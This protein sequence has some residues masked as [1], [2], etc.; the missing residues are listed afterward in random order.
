MR[1][2]PAALRVAPGI[3]QEMR[4]VPFS[5]RIDAFASGAGEPSSVA[6]FAVKP[7]KTTDFSPSVNASAPSMSPRAP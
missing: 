7:R 3:D 5:S 4:N 6:T 2:N 1:G